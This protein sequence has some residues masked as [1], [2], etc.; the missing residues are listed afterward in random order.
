MN[1]LQNP[2]MKKD[3]LSEEKL[4]TMLEGKERVGVSEIAKLLA[5]QFPKRR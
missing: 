5:R 3:V 1:G 2:G 4:R